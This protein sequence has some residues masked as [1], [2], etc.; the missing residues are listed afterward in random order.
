MGVKSWGIGTDCEWVW[1]SS[2]YD[3]NILKLDTGGS[4]KT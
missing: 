1:S 2:G 4:C 3:G